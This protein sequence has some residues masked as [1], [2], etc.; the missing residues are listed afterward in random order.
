MRALCLGRRFCGSPKVASQ[1]PGFTLVELLVVIAIIGILVGLLLPAVQAAREA[2]RRMQ[3][4][5]NLKQ[6]GLAAHNFESAN[7]K[8]PPGYIGEFPVAANMDA[9]NNS[10]VGHLVFLFPYMEATTIYN[11]WSS[12]RV[13]NSAAPLA[14]TVATAERWKYARWVDGSYS[15][16][17]GTDESLWNQHQY[18]LSMLLCPTDD[19][20]G[21][22]TGIITELRAT[23]GGI[24][25]SGYLELTALGR[26]NYLGVSG[27][28]GTGIASREAK[29]GIF[30]NRSSTKFGGISDG[31]SNTFMF[32][33][34]TGDWTDGSKPSGRLRSF[35]WNAGPMVSEWHRPTY[36]FSNSHKLWNNF[37]SMHTGILNWALGDGSVRSVSDSID[38]QLLIDVTSMADGIVTTLEN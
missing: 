9:A 31:T 7:K 30:F 16:T 22:S 3:C 10:Y 27:Q 6:L 33:E 13:L 37:S 11:Q 5:N 18:R 15:A 28:L 34:V 38:R 19:A 35:S 8:F 20:Y 23:T 1:R 36:G 2:A 21:N 12:E 24:S 17:G 26:T 25:R 4:T 29:K 14:S 32:G